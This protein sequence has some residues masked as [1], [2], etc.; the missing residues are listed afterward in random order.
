MHRQE[1][2]EVKSAI[3]A[4]DKNW[5]YDV[6]NLVAGGTASLELETFLPHRLSLL[7]VLTAQALAGVHEPHGLNNTEWIVLSSIAERPQTTAKDI[8][9]TFHMQKAKV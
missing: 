1:N 9:A 6:T 5:K 8:G 7:S 2:N 3:Q 4:D